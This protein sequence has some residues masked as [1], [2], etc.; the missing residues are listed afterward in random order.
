MN[1]KYPSPGT[2]APEASP[3]L[4]RGPDLTGANPGAA[5]PR[6]G[7]ESE[8]SWSPVCCV[9]CCQ[10]GT[11]YVTLLVCSTWQVPGLWG[12]KHCSAQHGHSPVINH[13][14]GHRKRTWAGAGAG[15]GG[16]P[17]PPARTS[18]LCG[19]DF[20]PEAPFSTLF[21]RGQRDR[22]DFSSKITVRTL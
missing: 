11:R 17:H 21:S 9:C 6:T 12:Q 14:T 18:T 7:P 15:A 19:S 1:V 13:R 8:V 10:S 2:R 16:R 22:N 4:Q 3:P 20:T 5:H